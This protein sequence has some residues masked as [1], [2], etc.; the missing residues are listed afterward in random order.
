MPSVH[1]KPHLLPRKARQ[2]LWTM[3]GFFC[4]G[5]FPTVML[6]TPVASM[7]MAVAGMIPFGI[8][9]KT[10]RQG[11]LRGIGLGVVAGVAISSALTFNRDIAPE[12]LGRLLA[13]FTAAT[14]VPCAGVGSLFAA[15][16]RRRRR[17]IDQ[18]WEQE[19]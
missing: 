13:T 16:T 9:S 10:V 15:L 2:V 14:V 11:L 17:L 7:A 12:A 5:Y 6:H 19:R 3:A 18:Q 8:R 1:D 4:A